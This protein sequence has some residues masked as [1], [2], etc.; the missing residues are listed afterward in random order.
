MKIIKLIFALNLLWAE[1]SI[2]VTVY[3]CRINEG[4]SINLSV[5]V[6]DYNET[7]HNEEKKNNE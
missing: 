6:K 1:S 2:D 7:Q 3:R 4:D 5:V